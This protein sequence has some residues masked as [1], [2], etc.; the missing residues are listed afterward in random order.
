MSDQSDVEA[1]LTELARHSADLS[2]VLGAVATCPA[3]RSRL[4][5]AVVRELRAMRP[6]IDAAMT[7]I[8]QEVEGDQP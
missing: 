4:W 1:T 5:P 3:R 2:L 6:K 7:L 8:E